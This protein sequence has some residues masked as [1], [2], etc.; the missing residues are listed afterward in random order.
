MKDNVKITVFTATYNRAYIIENLYNSLIVQSY[1]DF[2]WLIVDDGSTDNTEDLVEKWINEKKVR[3]RYFV[4]ENSGKHFAINYALGIAKGMYFFIVDSD[5]ILPN[6]SLEYIENVFGQFENE[7]IGGVVGRKAYF[8]GSYVGSN[9]NFDTLLSNPLEIRYKYKLSG[10][11]AEVF[12][13]EVL[14]LFPFPQFENEKFCPEALVW[15]RIAQDYSFV[16]FDKA[17]YNCEYLEDGLTKKIT[18]IRMLSPEASMLHYSE[19][20]SYNIPFLE[21][22]KANINYWR[23][24]FNSK[25]SLSKKISKVNLFRSLIGFPI[26]ILFYLND[27]RQ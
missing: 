6:N 8:N 24:S 15:N 3:I 9:N 12:K 2:E 20:E 14:K 1:K 21:K 22:V 27:L 7:G 23:F 5:D 18:R 26:G 4:Q 16:Y 17:V 11:L 19:L 25:K 10:D 13:T